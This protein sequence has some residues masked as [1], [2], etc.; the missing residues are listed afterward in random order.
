[1]K[2]IERKKDSNPTDQSSITI[3]SN[4]IMIIIQLRKKIKHINQ[5][6]YNKIIDSID[7]S[8]IECLNCHNHEWAFHA[9]YKRYID[10]FNRKHKIFITR[11]KC[12]FCNKTHAILID[13]MIPYSIADFDQIIN[14]INDHDYSYS[15]HISF[16][17]K[18]FKNI[19]NFSYIS[20]CILC[21][22]NH[23]CIFFNCST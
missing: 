7:F 23:Q 16:I 14:I 11:I 20:F 21:S 6:S 13:D 9:C 18:K 22:R 3:L 4:D 1:M 8:T 10:F 2:F 5:H 17:K 19:S 12:S 15:S